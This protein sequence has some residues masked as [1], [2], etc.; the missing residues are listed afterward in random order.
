M[1]IESYLPLFSGFYGNIHFEGEE[2]NVLEEHPDKTWEDFEWDYKE[3]H[4][5]MSR[6]CTSYIWNWFNSMGFKMDI[7]F[8]SLVSP[9]FYNYASD[10][11][12]V[13]YTISKRT[14][15]QIVQY[16]EENL[17]EFDSYLKDSYTSYEGFIP[18]HS[19]CTDDWLA[20]LLS[21]E[22]LEHKFGSILDFI[23]WNEGA[24]EADMADRCEKYINYKLKEEA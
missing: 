2:G 18:S 14:I 8:Q 21:G 17:S 23:M 5:R 1:K 16:L 19:N 9:R 20:V 13:E 6:E 10:S 4:E 24:D 12:N 3:Y 7:K 22:N 11:I 15:L